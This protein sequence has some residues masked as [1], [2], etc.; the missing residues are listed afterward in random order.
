MQENVDI[1]QSLPLDKQAMTR[2]YESAFPDEDLLPLVLQ[3]LS[4]ERGVLSLVALIDSAVAGHVVFTD[5]GTGGAVSNVALLGPLAVSADRQRMGIGGTLV[6]A[7]LE[8]LEKEGI[9][10]VCVLGDPAYYSRFG[11]T[12][13]PDVLPPYPL[14]N[15]WLGAWQSLALNSK[16]ALPN[17]VLSVPPP[18]QD[19]RLW[20]P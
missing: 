14:P 20:A 17:G 18:W 16:E 7:G 6:R 4:Q 1:R 19:R 2:H 13:E 5:C 12:P 8:H 3:L 9:G 10:F 15:E 11:F